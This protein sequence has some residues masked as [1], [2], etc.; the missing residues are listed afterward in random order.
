MA[1]SGNFRERES[2]KYLPETDTLRIVLSQARVVGEPENLGPNLSFTRTFSGSI[3]S[4]DVRGALAALRGVVELV[5]PKT[6]AERMEDDPRVKA[7]R[8]KALRDLALVKEYCPDAILLA[9]ATHMR[10]MRQIEEALPD[11]ADSDWQA[12]FPNMEDKI[13]GRGDIAFTEWVRALPEN[14][15]DKVVNTL[16]ENAARRHFRSD[17]SE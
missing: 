5:K 13:G 2:S 15:R 12:Q 14:G 1:T 10:R 4:V 6:A 8:E 9:R 7:D 11:G 17:N 16:D 3:A